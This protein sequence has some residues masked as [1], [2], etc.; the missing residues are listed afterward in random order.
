MIVE[1]VSKENHFL[2]ALEA[3]EIEIPIRLACVTILETCE[4]QCRPQD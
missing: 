1:F 2:T 3:G 4:I